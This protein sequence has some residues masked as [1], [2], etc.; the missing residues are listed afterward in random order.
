MPTTHP[1]SDDQRGLRF[2]VVGRGRLGRALAGALAAAGAPVEG[3]LGRGAAVGAHVDVVLLCVP[4][5]ELAAAAAAVPHGPLVG[6]CS[7]SAPLSVL[8][9]H[10]RFSAHPLMTVTEAG[11]TFSGAACAVDGSSARALD[12]AVGLA[13]RLGM[14]PVRVPAERRA[15]YHAAASMATNFL[16]TLEAAAERLASECGIERAHLAPL[17]RATVANWEA[18]GFGAITGPI[19]RGDDATVAAQ[20]A[21]VAERAADL[22]PLWD[23]LAERTRAMK[24][25]GGR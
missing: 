8:A 9:P 21:A 14:V 23:A 25:G 4:E 11:A 18:Q 12:A 5:R 1:I 20:R 10:E 7:A 16:V 3:P 22:L 19:A 24:A 17:V 15:L 6:H 13:T 2:T